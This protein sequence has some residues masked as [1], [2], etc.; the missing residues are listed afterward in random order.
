MKKSYLVCAFLAILPL[1]GQN[2][3]R[4]RFTKDHVLPLHAMRMRLLTRGQ[5]ISIY[6]WDLAAKQWCDQPHVQQTSFPYGI[7][8]TRVLMDGHPARLMYVGPVG[9]SYSTADQINLQIPMDAPAAGL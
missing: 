9:N 6:G 1:L 8:G 2:T 5:I 7:C 4:P 3:T